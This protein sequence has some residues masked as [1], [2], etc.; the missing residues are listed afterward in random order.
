MSDKKSET[1]GENL[2]FFGRKEILNYRFL[3][4]DIQNPVLKNR[5]R[6]SL[7]YF[8]NKADFYKKLN[9]LF[10]IIIILLPSAVTLISTFNFEEKTIIIPIITSVTTL[11]SSLLA[12]LKCNDKKKSYRDSAENLKSELSLFNYKAGI[13]KKYKFKMYKNQLITIEMPE[14]I[15]AKRIEV[16]IQNGYS[17]ISSLEDPQK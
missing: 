13:Y 9:V 2:P 3:Y 5:V 16:I 7:E 4:D 8:I 1:P 6:N 15:L 12:L 11:I 17:K 10:S 14:Q